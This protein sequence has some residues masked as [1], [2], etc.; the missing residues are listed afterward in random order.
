MKTAQFPK[1]QKLAADLAS[2]YSEKLKNA[3]KELE[4]LVDVSWSFAD[5]DNFEELRQE[6]LRLRKYQEGYI[7]AMK[8]A[9]A[10]ATCAYNHVSEFENFIV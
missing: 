5:E 1:E 8:C 6:N 3:E 9:L 4:R 7:S 2:I 10:E